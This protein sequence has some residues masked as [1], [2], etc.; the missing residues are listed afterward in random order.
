M[1]L[2][3]VSKVSRFLSRQERTYTAPKLPFPSQTNDSRKP[4]KHQAAK[5]DSRAK[6]DIMDLRD[7][8]TRL[9]DSRLNAS[10]GISTG[11]PM[12]ITSSACCPASTLPVPQ[13]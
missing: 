3:S 5:A 4:R 2:L 9:S 12:A 6:S 13:P 11:A 10:R 8:N 1:V 7:R